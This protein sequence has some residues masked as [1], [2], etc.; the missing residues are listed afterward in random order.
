MAGLLRR[1]LSD[2]A[3]AQSMLSDI[4]NEAKMAN[5][6]VLEVLDFVRPIRLQ[7]DTTRIARVV[8][9]AIALADRKL[10][11]RSASLTLDVP[12][13]LPDI[14]GDHQQLCQVLTNLLINACEAQV[15]GGAVH[16]T[17]SLVPSLDEGQ[18]D[19]IAVQVADDG[20]GIAPD[21]RERI[22]NPFFSTKP[23]GSGLGLAIV[24]KIVD[25]HEGRIDVASDVGR[26]TVFTVTLPVV[27]PGRVAF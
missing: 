7:V 9:D 23:Q 20:P 12:A 13:D 14:L 10:T 6:I 2:H 15:A 1:R 16:I 24:R 3:D 18:P 25:A 11:R 8:E 26:G 17:A 22:F 27:S 4:I 5:A 21:I 19:R